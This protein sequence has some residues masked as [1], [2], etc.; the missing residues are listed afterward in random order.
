MSYQPS[1]EILEKYADVM[2]NFAL[3]S[4]EGVRQGEVVQLRVSEV[5][6]PLLVALRRAVLQAG[7]HPLIFYTPDDFSREFYELANEDQLNFFPEKYLKGLID[8]ID[9]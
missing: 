2:I 6:K 4:G 5:A 7:A 9:H 8:Q 1:E 3:N